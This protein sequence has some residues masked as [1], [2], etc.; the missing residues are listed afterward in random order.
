MPKTRPGIVNLQ[1]AHKAATMVGLP[2]ALQRFTPSLSYIMGLATLKGEMDPS[3]LSAISST[4]KFCDFIRARIPSLELH[5][6]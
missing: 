2:K 3:I 1:L 5:L 4:T 6:D